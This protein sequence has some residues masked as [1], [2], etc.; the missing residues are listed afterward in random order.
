MLTKYD[1]YLNTQDTMGYFVFRS[2]RLTVWWLKKYIHFFGQP[3]SVFI[4]PTEKTTAL[5][6][7][8]IWILWFASHGDL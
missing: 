8:F 3:N 7:L 6:N 5:K 2:I 4:T 1:K